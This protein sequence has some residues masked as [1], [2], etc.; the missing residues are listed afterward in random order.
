VK[1]TIERAQKAR[2]LRE[3]GAHF[4][5]FQEG[6]AFGAQMR[7]KALN[8]STARLDYGAAYYVPPTVD[9]P[10]SAPVPAD[11]DSGDGSV[12][13]TDLRSSY[14]GEPDSLPA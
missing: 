11:S 1:R 8:N 2:G 9:A 4:K 5:M 14:T 12:D 3:K 7:M 13:R 10:D 6:A